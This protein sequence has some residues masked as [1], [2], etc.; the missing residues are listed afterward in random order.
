VGFLLAKSCSIVLKKSDPPSLSRTHTRTTDS[1]SFPGIPV[2]LQSGAPA[3]RG[4]EGL[5]Q[6]LQLAQHSTASMGRFDEL[7]KGE[8]APKM[9]GK[10]RSFRDNF[11]GLGDAGGEKDIMKKQLRIVQDKVDKKARGV[12]NS[13]AEYEGILPDAPTDAFRQRKG[14]GKVS[15]APKANSRD[16]RKREKK[17]GSKLFKRKH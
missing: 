12:T 15:G 7:R 3:K 10:K 6:A 16:G 2:G 9:K 1:T 11:E 4:K 14:K 5:K 8:P 17:S 13:L